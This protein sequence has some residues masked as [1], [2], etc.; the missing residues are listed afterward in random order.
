MKRQ[1]ASELLLAMHWH[2]REALTRSIRL[3]LLALTC[4]EGRPGK[5]VTRCLVSAESWANIGITQ[6]VVVRQTWHRIR[7]QGFPSGVPYPSDIDSLSLITLGD[8]LG[9]LIMCDC[10]VV[11]LKVSVYS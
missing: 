9:V 6:D 1:G 5:T 3:V 10:T 7:L 8:L 2:C 4:Y 11:A